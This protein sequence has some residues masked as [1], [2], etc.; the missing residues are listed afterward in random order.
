MVSTFKISNVKFALQRIDLLGL[1]QLELL[2]ENELATDAAQAGQQ[3][4]VNWISM[5]AYFP[6]RV[7]VSTVLAREMKFEAFPFDEEFLAEPESHRRLQ[8]RSSSIVCP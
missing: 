2:A 1:S 5:D 3:M 6:T 4:I 7:E 8:G